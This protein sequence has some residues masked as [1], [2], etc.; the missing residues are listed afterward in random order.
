MSN[1][2][3]FFFHNVKMSL[4][5]QSLPK[6][7]DCLW[8]SMEPISKAVIERDNAISTSTGRIRKPNSE[9]FITMILPDT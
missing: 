5:E 8:C 3:S 2:F 1:P 7:Q 9:A 4:L 6:L